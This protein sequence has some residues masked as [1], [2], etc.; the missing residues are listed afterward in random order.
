MFAEIKAHFLGKVDHKIFEK[1]EKYVS[2][3]NIQRTAVVGLSR[4]LPGRVKYST[5]NVT[6]LELNHQEWHWTGRYTNATKATAWNK[7][8]WSDFF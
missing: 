7:I 4:I 6:A 3:C 8:S 1:K 2:Y 5:T